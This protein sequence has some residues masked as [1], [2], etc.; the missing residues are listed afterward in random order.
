[1]GKR[2]VAWIKSFL[3]LVYRKWG[4]RVPVCPSLVKR[5]SWNPAEMGKT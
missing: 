2:A 5:V 3:E 4:K 1:M